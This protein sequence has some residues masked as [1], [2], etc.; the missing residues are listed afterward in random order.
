MERWPAV[1][2]FLIAMVAVAVL[3]G[4]MAL[5]LVLF[6][7]HAPLAWGVLAVLGLFGMCLWHDIEERRK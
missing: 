4:S 5:S 6:D 2:A 3:V 7:S 1:T